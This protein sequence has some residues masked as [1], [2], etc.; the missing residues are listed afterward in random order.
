MQKTWFILFSMMGLLLAFIESL[1]GQKKTQTFTVTQVINAP[2]HEVWQVVGQDYGAIANSHPK[3]VSSDYLV[4]SLQAG[5]GAE[6]VCNFNEKGTRFLHEKQ[7]HFDSANYTFRNQV[8]KAGR[9]PI[10]PDYTFADYKVEPLDE[11]SSRFTFNM[12]F[13]TKPAFM[14][15]MVKGKFKRLIEDYVIA[16]DHHVKTGENVNK[17]NFKQIKRAYASR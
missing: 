7:T 13:R 8:F 6:R 14:G 1:H 10:D 2:A 3:I 11:N 5:E 4:G 17:S 9:F 12:N 16:V 15:G